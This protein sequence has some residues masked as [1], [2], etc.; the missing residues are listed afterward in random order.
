MPGKKMALRWELMIWVILIQDA[1][2]VT[3]P[4]REA[5]TKNKRATFPIL[6]P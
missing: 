1:E 4:L 6:R 3:G 5:E 2:V